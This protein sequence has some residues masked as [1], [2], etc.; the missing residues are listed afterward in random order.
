MKRNNFVLL[1]LLSACLVGCQNSKAPKE[2]YKWDGYQEAI[3]QYYKGD[4][5][6][7]EQIAALQKLVEQAKASAKPVPPGL[8]AQLGLLFSNAGK[9]DDAMAEFNLEKQLF[10]ESASYIDFLMSKGK[11]SLK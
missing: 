9:M 4:T 5:T 1:C 2:I 7:A 11:G 10:P 3:Y 6:P 8:H